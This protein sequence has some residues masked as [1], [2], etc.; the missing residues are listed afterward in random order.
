M[1]RTAITLVAI[2]AIT[3]TLAGAATTDRWLHIRVEERDGRGERVKVNLPLSMLGK[4][5]GAIDVEEIDGHSFRGGR[6]RISDTDIDH[7][8][9]RAMWNAVKEADDMEFV[10][11]ESTEENVSVAKDQGYLLVRVR[12]GQDDGDDDEALDDDRR[13]GERVD[14]KVPLAVVDALLSAGEKE[15]DLQ[16]A[17]MALAES[18]EGVL[19]V[20]EDGRSSVRIWIDDLNSSE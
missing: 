15:L 10:N 5:A 9:L 18:G 1:K 2:L 16:A 12:P 4:V 11:I 6:V 13:R 19:V 20:V 14:I 8:D 7:V 17:L 3:A